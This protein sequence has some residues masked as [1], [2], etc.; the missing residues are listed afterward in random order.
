MTATSNSL[1]TSR[2]RK[3]IVGIDPFKAYAFVEGNRVSKD[4]EEV[5]DNI[6]FDDR[7]LHKHGKTKFDLFIRNKNNE[8]FFWKSIIDMP[9]IIENDCDF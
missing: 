6:E 1:E 7:F 5:I 2:I 8:V 4:R 3:I 9:V